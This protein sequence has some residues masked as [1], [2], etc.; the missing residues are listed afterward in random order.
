M[1]GKSMLVPRFADTLI[2]LDYIL[3]MVEQNIQL[4]F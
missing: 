3:S 4:T 2:I 1:N